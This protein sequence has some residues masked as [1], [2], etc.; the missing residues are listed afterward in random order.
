MLKVIVCG[1]HT[2]DEQLQKC[3]DSI[4]MQSKE[5]HFVLSLD[6]DSPQRRYLLKNTR[7]AIDS[8]PILLPNDVIVCIDADD[9]LIDEDT[10][11]II[12]DAYEE[13]PNL[14]LTYGSYVNLSSNKRG[15]F[16]GEYLPD[17]S[18]RTSPWRGSHLKTFKY[19]LWQA[20]P[21]TQ[22]QWDNGEWFKCCA[23]RAMMIPMMELAGHDRIKYI[24][25]L[26][27]CYNDLNPESVWKTN[28]E[29]S[30]KT[31]DFIAARSPLQRLETI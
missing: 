8:F 22:L 21:K 27:Y 24:D 3:F 17:E 14:L 11:R 28:R 18:F 6:P 12:H 7:C 15:K 26:L 4:R 29:L 30:L 10:F 23:D 16:C 2:E 19:K 25:M 20:L 31:R 9:W 5:Y 1:Y 13:N